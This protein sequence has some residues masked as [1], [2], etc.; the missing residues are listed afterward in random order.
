MR[1]TSRSAFEEGE[2][3]GEREI[4]E[5]HKRE[6]LTRGKDEGGGKKFSQEQY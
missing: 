6:S 1:K 5:G 2:N 4:I 3:G